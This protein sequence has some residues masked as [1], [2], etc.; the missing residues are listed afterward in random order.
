MDNTPLTTE[1]TANIQKQIDK[2]ASD[3]Q[4]N[5]YPLPYH[6][7]NGVDSSLVSTITGLGT[8]KDNGLSGNVILAGGTNI[9]V[10]QSGQT[11][12]VTDTF[13]STAKVA[14]YQL[15]TSNNTWTKPSGVQ[16]G[17]MVYVQLWGGGG[18]GGGTTGT[19]LTESGAGGGGEYIEI[20]FRASD[21]NSTVSVVVGV[22]STGGN[23]NGNN[24]ADGNASSFAGLI[25]RG[26]LKGISGS[27]TGFGGAGG[28]YFP[29]PGGAA[30]GGDSLDGLSGGGGSAASSGK[31]GNSYKGG[32]GGATGGQAGGTSL[33]GGKGGDAP[34]GT[35]D[36]QP[37]TAPSGGGSGAHGAGSA[38]K[39][40]DGA[41]GEA[42]IWTIF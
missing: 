21:L 37:G 7:H 33:L 20:W 15:F 8:T 4:Y 27:G 41:R 30:L 10:S 18:A 35:G 36:G 22:A 11:I 24:G 3:G 19:V 34:S 25:A 13:T 9:T 12:T 23:G 42:R 38:K 32:G 2:T 28:G 14:D 31:G 17:S 1:Q 6:T 26:G 39:G 29:G 16:T 40:G 5:L